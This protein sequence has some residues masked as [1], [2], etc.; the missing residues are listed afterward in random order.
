MESQSPFLGLENIEGILLLLAPSSSSWSCDL[1]KF[2]VPLFR[3][4]CQ[5]VNG[6]MLDPSIG[7]FVLTD[8]DMRVKPRGKIYSINEGY[9]ERW[10]PAVREYVK[11]KKQVEYITFVNIF[12]IL[13]SIPLTSIHMSLIPI[14]FTSFNIIQFPQKP[15]LASQNANG[16]PQKVE[17]FNLS[18]FF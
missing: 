13:N 17:R 7:E 18:P 15:W 12:N 8:A 3:I 9:E 10:Q 14:T 5:G 6:F 4:D 11:S 2:P 1:W 16:F